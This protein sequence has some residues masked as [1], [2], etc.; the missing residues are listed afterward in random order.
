MEIWSSLVFP[1][2]SYDS[3]QA[4]QFLADLMQTILFS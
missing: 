1:L 2:N 3:D 4:I